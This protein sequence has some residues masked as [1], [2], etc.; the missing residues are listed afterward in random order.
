[1]SFFRGSDR[2]LIA[3]DAVVTTRQESAMSVMLQRAMV[4]RP[5]AYYT[6]DW[7]AARR[8]VETIAALE[9]EFLATGHGQAL[10]GPVMRDGLRQLAARFDRIRP[11]RGRYVHQPAIADERGLVAV[12]A[13]RATM[14]PA[15]A[16]AAAGVLGAAVVLALR[17]R[18]R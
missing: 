3:G 9:P 10:R 14:S 7:Q 13:R 15:L 11:R 12:P 6:S 16:G 1:V 17:Q 5:P 18:A 4:W 8:S 2:T